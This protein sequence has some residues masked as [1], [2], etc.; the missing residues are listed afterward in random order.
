MDC[1]D[2]DALAAEAQR[3][4]TPP[5]W[6]FCATGADDEI[7]AGENVTAWRS[8]RLRPRVLRDIVEVDTSVTL[9][10]TRVATPVMV[11]PTGRHHLF[12]PDAER[13]TARGAAAAGAIYVMA[14][15]GTTTV[16]EVA[17]ERGSP[18]Q[19][20]QLY[21]Q[22]DRGETGDL[23]DRCV[24]AGFSALVLTVDQPVPGWSPRS[25][26]TPVLPD[27]KYRSVNMIGRP[28]ARTAYDISRKGV[29]MFPTNFADLEWIAGRTRLPV[30][31]KGVMRGDD[32]IRCVEAGARGVIVSN[33]GGRHLDTVV[34]TADALAEVAG[35]VGGKAEV[36]AD[37]GI[38]RGTDIVK[39]MALGARAVLVGR[40]PLW[41]LAVGGAEGVQSVMEHLQ[42]EFV[43]AMRLCGVSRLSDLT[44]DLVTSWLR[45]A[46]CAPG[47]PRL[48]PC[49]R[50][51]SS[52]SRAAH[53]AASPRTCR[54]TSRAASAC[55]S[56]S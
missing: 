2:F 39:A 27:P 20:F 15:S 1:V 11:A 34:T 43:R 40:P 7:T 13:G 54:R 23:L 25:F 48:R 31:V 21:M 36:Y 50:C 30:V 38:R 52:G 5:A 49:P 56:N 17:A 9:L 14:T 35:A 28:V 55:R 4:M 3:M 41:G 51:S 8:L 46:C 45:P 32:A 42:D 6:A 16:E 24:A 26:R 19:W 22:P 12:H 37:G 44:P 10:G 53:R 29:V 33:H 47:S 18:P